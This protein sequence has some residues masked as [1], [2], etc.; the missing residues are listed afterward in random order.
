MSQEENMIEE[1]T[2][3]QELPDA[4]PRR[5]IR[6]TISGKIGIFFV[7]FWIMMVLIGPYVAP[8]NEADFLDESLFIVPG[9]DEY[10]DTDYQPPSKV[11]YLGTD[12]LGRDTL[13]LLYTSP[14]P[15]D[16]TLSRMPSSA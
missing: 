5:K 9:G 11:A 8:Y 4:P 12:Y 3:F 1:E 13:C 14:S 2:A 10:P 16:A 7:L 6:F 15:R